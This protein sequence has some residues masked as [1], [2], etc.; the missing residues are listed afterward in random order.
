MAA[1][2]AHLKLALSAADA[3]HLVDL[4]EPAIRRLVADGV[5]A[6]MPGTT[7]LLI[8]RIELER[9]AASSSPESLKVWEASYGRPVQMSVGAA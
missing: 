5:I 1:V 9:W 3:G 7:R 4:S 6:R 2:P 8:A